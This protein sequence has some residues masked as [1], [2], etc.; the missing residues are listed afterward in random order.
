[1]NKKKRCSEKEKGRYALDMREQSH[2]ECVGGAT[3]QIAEQRYQGTA[4]TI[5]VLL[6][7]PH[8]GAGRQQFVFCVQQR[9]E[10]LF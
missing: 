8:S 3:H 7:A 5:G 6:L 2:G 9:G 4:V 10:E 1:M